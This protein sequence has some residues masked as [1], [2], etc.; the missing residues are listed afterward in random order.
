MIELPTKP[1]PPITQSPT[2]LLLY[3]P[4]KV[5]KSSS[6]VKLDRNMVF[7]LESGSKLLSGLIVDVPSVARQEEIRPLDVLRRYYSLLKQNGNNHYRFITFDTV[8]VLEDLLIEEISQ[9]HGVGHISDLAYGR[10]DSLLREEFLKLV[11]AFK[12]LGTQIILI[13]HRKRSIIGD[14]GAEVIIKELGLR[15]KMRNMIMGYA[16]AI[17]YV[18]SSKNH[19]MVS[20]KTGQNEDVAAGSRCTYLANK[21]ITLAEFNGKGEIIRTHWEIIYPELN[22]NS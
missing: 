13:G 9:K 16:D 11:S 3:G 20:F 19:L 1:R 17:G 7:D 8:D 6:V 5:G 14:T 4:P 15:G 22:G 18:F 2:V 21:E 10:G 12:D